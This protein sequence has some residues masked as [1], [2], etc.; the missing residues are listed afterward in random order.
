MLTILVQNMGMLS[1]HFHICVGF[2]T[3]A[4]PARIYLAGN[5]YPVLNFLLRYHEV[6]WNNQIIGCIAYQPMKTSVILDSK[7]KNICISVI[8]R[9]QIFPFDK[10]QLQSNPI[11]SFLYHENHDLL[12]VFK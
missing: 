8:N 1:H 7:D 6:V 3:E 10:N 2:L 5:M 4:F 9:Q 12:H 11:Y